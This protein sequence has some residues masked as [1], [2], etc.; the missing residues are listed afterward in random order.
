[1]GIRLLLHW[2]GEVAFRSLAICASQQSAQ[3]EQALRIHIHAGF[4]CAGLIQA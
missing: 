1:M 4:G 2:F 3:A